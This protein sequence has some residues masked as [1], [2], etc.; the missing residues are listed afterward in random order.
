LTAKKN[1]LQ[2]QKGG[3]V[4]KVGKCFLI[5]KIKKMFIEKT[6]AIQ[7]NLHMQVFN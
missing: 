2:L 4:G 1:N 7:K 3:K 6:E 5:F